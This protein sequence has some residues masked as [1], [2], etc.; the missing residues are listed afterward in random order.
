MRIL[1]FF[2]VDLAK[3][4]GKAQAIRQGALLAIEKN[5]DFIGFWDADH[6]TPLEEIPRFISCL[7]ENDSL[8]LVMGSRMMRLGANIQR[9]FYS[10]AKDRVFAA[11]VRKF[12]GLGVFDPQCG[13]KVMSFEAANLVFKEKFSSPAYFDVE[14]LCRLQQLPYSAESP[15]IYELPLNQWKEVSGSKLKM[16]NLLNIP[17]ELKKISLRYRESMGRKLQTP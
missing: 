7:S 11:A 16:S 4:L 17:I 6:A 13:A 12:T 14:I 9:K 3:N 1:V 5:Y 2:Y 10:Y 8:Q 15:N